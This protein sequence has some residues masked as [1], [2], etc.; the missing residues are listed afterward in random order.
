MMSYYADSSKLQ[1][2]RFS[3][4]CY[5]LLQH[6]K[7]APENLHHF[8]RTY[9]LPK[10]PFFPL[11]FKIKREY[12][13]EQQRKQE[14]RIRYIAARMRSL[15]EPTLEFV[16]FLARFEQR[17]NRSGRYPVWNQQLFPKSKKRAREYLEFDLAAWLSFFRGYLECLGE[18]Y[19]RIDE[20]TREMLL[21]CFVLQCLPEEAAGDG[22]E[23]W[24]DG[25]RVR[26][27]YRRLSLEHH[28]DRGGSGE[29]FVE[30]KRA[31]DLLI[32]DEKGTGPS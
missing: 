1:N 3:R 31:R 28:P 6:A 29:L 26:R 22:R 17:C 23:V 15:P 10:D 30:L 13:L 8:Y 14:E 24:P 20:H 2:L 18:R 9:R 25:E 27:Q 12:L 5:S 16:K 21:A 4:R 11:F 7:I 19:R 32:G